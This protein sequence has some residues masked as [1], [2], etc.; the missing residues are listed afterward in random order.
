MTNIP[1]FVWWSKRC[2]TLKEELKEYNID[3]RQKKELEHPE[4]LVTWWREIPT[5][6]IFAEEFFDHFFRPFYLRQCVQTGFTPPP[7]SE[8]KN[9]KTPIELFLADLNGVWVSL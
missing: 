1:I 2:Q 3:K 9:M 8:S 7:P 4:N 5:L 6:G